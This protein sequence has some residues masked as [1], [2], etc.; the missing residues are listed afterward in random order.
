[1]SPRPEFDPTPPSPAPKGLPGNL[2]RGEELLWQGRPSGR[3]L[4]LRMFHIVPLAAYFGVIIAWCAVRSLVHGEP[5][6]PVA[7]STLKLT[8]IALV[9][10]AL[11]AVYAWLTERATVYTITNRRVAIRLGVA[12]PMTLNLPLRSIE[13]VDLHLAGDGSGDLALTVSATRK[14]SYMVLWPHARPW[15]MARPTPMLRAIP[16]AARVA[17]ILSHALDAAQPVPVRLPAQQP[18]LAATSLANAA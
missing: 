17:E 15:R 18:D 16:D 12:L 2:P 4:A 13:S 14:V 8:G 11:I 3:A 5:V 9:P 6:V 7:L 1:M 10:I